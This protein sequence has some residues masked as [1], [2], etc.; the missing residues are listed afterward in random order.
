MNGENKAR[1]EA[2]TEE[3]K[4]EKGKRE[5]NDREGVKKRVLTAE[6]IS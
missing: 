1:K 3:R 4:E 5:S 2:E 6:S